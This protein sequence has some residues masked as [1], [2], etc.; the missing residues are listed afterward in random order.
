MQISQGLRRAVQIRGDELA[1]TYR[2]RRRSWREVAGR[3]RR[4][5]GAL[6]GLGVGAGDRV[7]ILAFNADRYLECQ[8]AVPWAGAVIVPLNTRWAAP[9]HAFALNDS[10]STVLLVDD[11]FA[12]L[13]ETLR[14]QLET[15]RT[16][17]FMGD[18]AVPPG[19]LGYEA[20]LEAARP[21]EDAGRADDDLA[22][23]YYTGGTTGR[24][25]GVMLSHRNIV[26]NAMN[27]IAT[28]R[29]D[30]N[31]RWLHSAPMFHLADGAGCYGVTIMGGSHD[32]VPKFDPIDVFETIQREQVTFGVLV[33]TMINML[34]NHPRVRDFDLS[35]LAT[36]CFGASPMPVAVLRK[37]LAELPQTRWLHGYGMTET[38]P[39]ATVL[40]WEFVGTEGRAAER[41][42]SCG[43]AVAGCEVRIVDEQDREVPRGTVG[44]IACRGDNVMLG[45]WKQPELTR[46]ALRGGWMH[47][48]DAAW[49]DDE[50]FVYIVDRVKD[51]IISGGENIYSAEV[52]QAVYQHPAVAECAV[53]GIPDDAWGEAVHAVVVP[54]P[55]RRLEAQAI[56]DH[57]HTLIAGYKCPRSVEIRSAP[58]PLSG[59]GKI[60]KTELRA[61]FWQDRDRKV[62]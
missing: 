48:G 49:M 7:A 60:L 21:A 35:S 54:K 62:N 29:I 43:R 10:A 26:W 27:A 19:M 42:A 38:A 57:C 47:T 40:E 51:M 5:A 13:W 59:A 18:G 36:V 32:F 55:G 3:V 44:E 22:G 17:V 39:V 20:I 31:A 45:Y 41:L 11:G 14:P 34:V 37:A 6:H 8:L 28:F 15:V 33:P 52:E 1:T 24:S 23:I 30:H 56:I 25:K 9:E 16:V 46:Q 12:A 2:G 50:G 53:I 58:L 4:L 61:P